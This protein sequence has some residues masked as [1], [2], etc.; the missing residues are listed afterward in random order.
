[1][2]VFEYFKS[3]KKLNDELKRKESQ[4]ELMREYIMEQKTQ[5]I[6]LKRKL[7]ITEQLWDI[8]SQKKTY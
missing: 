7:K 2:N 8:A 5:I 1:M 6:E 3:K 4:I